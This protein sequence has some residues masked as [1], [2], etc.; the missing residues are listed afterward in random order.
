MMIVEDP[1]DTT[2]DYH[3]IYAYPLR[4]HPSLSS[5][6][7]DVIS[8]ILVPGISDTCIRHKKGETYQYPELIETNNVRFLLTGI[9][10]VVKLG[11]LFY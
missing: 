8:D 5:G 2:A 6:I 10:L 11:Q 4:C 9:V 1:K 7:S 3:Y